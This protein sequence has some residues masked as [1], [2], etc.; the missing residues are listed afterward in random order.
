M[1]SRNT[2]IP[3]V[4]T[5]AAPPPT[6]MMTLPPPVT[7]TAAAP[8]GTVPSGP[9]IGD[10]CND[11]M[12]FA[13]DPVSGQEMICDNYSENISRD[14]LKWF[15]AEKGAVGP[16]HHHGSNLPRRQ[17]RGPSRNTPLEA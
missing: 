14:G 10:V 3:V 12:K 7:V 13:T 17:R 1:L 2:K 8:T 11:R 4:A 9:T 6:V 16:F 5:V 15:S